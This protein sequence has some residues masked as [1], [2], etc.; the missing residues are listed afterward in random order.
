MRFSDPAKVEKWFKRNCSDVFGRE[1]DAQEPT[2][3]TQAYETECASCHMASPPRLL[4]QKNWQNIMA[5][6]GKHFGWNAILDA[7][8]QSEI[9]KHY[10][11]ALSF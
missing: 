1:F 2:D 9:N 6:L 5:R 3:A 10:F 4:S 11:Y 7:K 8:T